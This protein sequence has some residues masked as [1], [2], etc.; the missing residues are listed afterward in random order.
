[1]TACQEKGL[2][3]VVTAVPPSTTSDWLARSQTQQVRWALDQTEWSITMWTEESERESSRAGPTL[4]R[5]R[6][7][8]LVSGTLVVSR[9]QLL[10]LGPA[11]PRMATRGQI[12]KGMAPET[13][14]PCYSNTLNLCKTLQQR[15]RGRCGAL[16]D[17]P[18]LLEGIFQHF[19]SSHQ[20]LFH[21][22]LSFPLSLQKCHLSL[23][24]HTHRD[25]NYKKKKETERS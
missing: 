19:D 13:A 11:N 6:L 10:V 2:T 15:R 17:S 1:M 22:L 7:W 23:E 18:L 9:L 20:V 14:P 5:L 4:L 16:G 25:A 12:F 3:C 8:L 24:I 21:V